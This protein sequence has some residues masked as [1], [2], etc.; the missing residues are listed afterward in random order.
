MFLLQQNIGPYNGL[1][2]L[3]LQ[4]YASNVK[5]NFI[6]VVYHSHSHTRRSRSEKLGSG[7]RHAWDTVRPM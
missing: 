6:S 1:R 4:L 7:A 2:F 5:L 3:P